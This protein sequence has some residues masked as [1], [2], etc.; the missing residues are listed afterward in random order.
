MRRYLRVVGAVL[1][2]A[3]VAAAGGCKAEE[4]P[5]LDPKVAPPAVSKAG[6]LMA[7]VDL[8]TPPFGGTEKGR[9]AGLDVDVAAALAEKLG[10]TVQYVDVSP[11]DAATALA[12]GKVDVVLS[13][14]PSASSLSAMS[15]AGSYVTDAPVFFVTTES[16]ESIEPSLTLDSALP[17][18]IAVQEGSESFWI[19][20]DE[21]GS[22]A[23]A[24]HP[25]LQEAFDALTSG[26]VEMVAGDAL[27]GAYMV[28]DTPTLQIAGQ[29]APASPLAVAVAAENA[30]LGEAVRAALDE[31]A[32]G[33]VFDTLRSKWV[34]QAPALTGADSQEE[35]TP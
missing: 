29:L 15:L 9:Q 6:V 25:T 14:P 12:E 20:S 2:V 17:A 16:T 22:E 26:E 4:A 7:G 28:R 5:K 10:L 18:K 1:L 23:I 3:A 31:L 33:G 27:V 21:L 19:L 32:A 24:V 13:V 34:G 35:P 11:S 8:N 30:S